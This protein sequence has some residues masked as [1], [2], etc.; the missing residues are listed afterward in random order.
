MDARVATGLRKGFALIVA[1]HVGKVTGMPPRAG[2]ASPGLV[3]GSEGQLGD[4]KAALSAA[5]LQVQAV[6][7]HRRIAFGGIERVSIINSRLPGKRRGRRP[8]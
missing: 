2:I 1:Q 3:F 6:A 7:I 5:E 4:E 8:G